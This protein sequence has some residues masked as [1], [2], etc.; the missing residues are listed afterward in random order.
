MPRPTWG[1]SLR[2]SLG[3]GMALTFSGA[4]LIALN[5]W[6]GSAHGLLLIAPL[7]ATA[8]LIFAVPNSPLAQPWSAVVGNGVSAFVAVSILHWGLSLELAAGFSILGAMVAMAALRAMHPPGAAVALATVL[9]DPLSGG[10]GYSFVAAPVIFDTVLL[11]T[12]AIIYNRTTGRHYPFRQMESLGVHSTTDPTPERR[13][14]LSV[15]DLSLLLDRFNLSA[16]IGAEDFGRLLAAAE[17]EAARRHFEG[18]TCGAVMSRDLIT[19][20]PDTPV[21]V[22]AELFRR[23]SFKTLPVVDDGSVP[24]G[25]ITQNDLI[26]RARLDSM[27]GGMGFAA[28]LTRIARVGRGRHLRACDIM[29]ADMRTVGPTDS[30]SILVQMLADDGVQAAPVVEG[31]RLVGIVT[32]SDLIAALACQTLLAGTLSKDE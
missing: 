29:T 30:I 8:F 21:G 28:A 31:L 6:L 18:M 17:A 3:A 14:G 23:H 26:Q 27:V 2:A 10:L 4:I 5:S 32:R 22:V 13:V 16:N 12:I 15:H 19:V 20:T 1:E 9:T 7:G 25:I 24:R 11:V